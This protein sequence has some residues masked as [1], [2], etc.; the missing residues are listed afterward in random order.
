M[1]LFKLLSSVGLGGIFFFLCLCEFQAQG[2]IRT[3]NSPR[4]AF[5]SP[6]HP[7]LIAAIA[8]RVNFSL[9]FIL[10]TLLKSKF[11]SH[12]ASEHPCSSE[13]VVSL[14]HV[15]CS[16]VCPLQTSL[17]GSFT[18]HI[19]MCASIHTSFSLCSLGILLGT[20]HFCLCHISDASHS[21][22]R[23]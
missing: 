13:I 2:Q 1:I 5:L 21:P 22:Q 10:F 23:S 4:M 16:L 8:M 12:E 9:V 7:E 17:L 15:L 18:L 11:H 20:F 14:Y 19:Y 6:S 3:L